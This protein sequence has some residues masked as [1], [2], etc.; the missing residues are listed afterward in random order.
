[1]EIT[2]KLN[3][4]HCTSESTTKNGK[5][6]CKKQNYIC[7]C[8]R[9]QF[10]ADH[11]RQKNRL[12]DVKDKV[13]LM[14]VRN[15][16]IR[17]IAVILAI[18]IKS[19]LKILC[20]S[21]YDMRPKKPHYE[22][23]EVDEF[24]TYVGSKSKKV[25]LIYAYCRQ[26]GEIVF[27]TWGKRNIKTVNKLKK[28]LKAFDITYDKIWSDNWSSFIASFSEANHLVGKEYT[29]GIEWNNCRLRHRIR[30]AV[31]RTCCFSKKIRNY[32]KAFE[33]AFHYINFGTV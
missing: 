33:M 17:D 1:M 25:W 19:V 18:S 12:L 8:C 30:R 32:I 3:C 27:W 26:S 6:A 16:G 22:N 23:L 5:K 21:T 29:K 11:E 31:R 15:C 4:P 28:R 13:K 20:S 2:Y 10:I 24:W 14:L 7:K 9:K